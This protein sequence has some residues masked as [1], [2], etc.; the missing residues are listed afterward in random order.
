MINN[1]LLKIQKQSKK[2]TILTILFISVI[3]VSISV[4]IYALLK[5]SVCSESNCKNHESHK[6]CH[7]HGICQNTNCTCHLKH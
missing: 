6:I 3:I 4:S 2:Q 1:K 7:C 5:K